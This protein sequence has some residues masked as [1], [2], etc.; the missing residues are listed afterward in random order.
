MIVV[1]IVFEVRVLHEY[2]RIRSCGKSHSQRSAFAAI[3]RMIENLDAAV[4]KVLQKFASAVG[5]SI[6]DD[7]HLGIEAAVE[8]PVYNLTNCFDFVIDRDHDRNFDW[9]W[10]QP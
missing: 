5:G 2:E 1:R 10:H 9:I 3:F 6:I 4:V 8:H 7:Y